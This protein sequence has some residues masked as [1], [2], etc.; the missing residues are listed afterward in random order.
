MQEL[1]D[2]DVCDVVVDG[3]AQ[4]DDAIIEQSGVNVIRALAAGRTAR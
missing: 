4:E 3:A 2:N 1:R